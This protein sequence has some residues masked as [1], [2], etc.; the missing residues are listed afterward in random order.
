MRV[1]ILIA[2]TIMLILAG[3]LPAQ[4][5]TPRAQAATLAG[6]TCSLG[7]A[8][9][10]VSFEPG[11]LAIARGT[12]FDWVAESASAVTEY[13]GTF[14]VRRLHVIIVPLDRGEGVVFGR[15]FVPGPVPVIRVMLGRIVTNE[16]LRADWIMTHEMVHLAFPSVPEKHHWIEEG[17]ATYVEPIA[18]AQIGDLIARRVWR[19]MFEGMPHGLPAAGDRG[20]DNTHTWG[21]T[22]WGG[23]LFC[24]LADVEI[25]R[26][27]NN[28]FGLQDALRAIAKSGN[29]LSDWPLEHA[30]K[31][32]DDAVGVPVLTEL[33]NK[34]KD[35]PADPHLA[36]LWQRLGVRDTGDS[37]AFD[38]NAPDA[39][40]VTSIMKPRGNRPV[41]SP[42]RPNPT[43]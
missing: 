30:L 33:Y 36:E 24:L 16:H 25:H 18:R 10:E 5:A 2:F 14:P 4:A 3:S 8:D 37:V 21:R 11:G 20:L 32:G 6:A 43:P 31:V 13:Y 40:I 42:W 39:S 23:A 38:A 15:T 17:I 29:M 26:R 12:V 28:R 35:A 41:A 1:R 27:T 22:Y 7:G 19:D 34:M 9:I